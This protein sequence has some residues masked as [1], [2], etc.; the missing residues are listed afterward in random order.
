MVLVRKDGH[1]LTLAPL[2][3]GPYKVISRSLKTF[4]L[5]VG[6]RTDVVSVQ[7]LKPA[8]TSEEEQPA[9]PPRRGRPRR[10]QPDPL[11]PVQPDPPPPVTRRRGRP[12]KV[13]ASAS[14]IIPTRRKKVTFKLTPVI[15]GDI[16]RLTSGV[17]PPASTLG[18]G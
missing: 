1:V 5:Q 14:T 12:R 15:I 7:R 9:L 16:K 4:R 11:P 3:K 17:K 6:E 2:Y 8:V 18:G 10:V 13:A